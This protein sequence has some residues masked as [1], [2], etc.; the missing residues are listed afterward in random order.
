MAENKQYITQAQDNGVLMISEDVIA[1]IVAHAVSE[2]DGVVSLNMKPGAD[3]AEL[4]GKK[5]WARGIKVTINQND[6][7]RIDCNISVRYGQSVVN[8][9]KATQEAIISELEAIAGLKIASVNMN[10]CGI[11]HQ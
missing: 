5:N 4:I 2:V 8:V 11:T 1:D 9:S 3:I 10:V 6:E 7:V